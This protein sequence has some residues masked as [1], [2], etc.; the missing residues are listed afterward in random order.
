MTTPEKA[1]E[2]RIRKEL[3]KVRTDP[4]YLPPICLRC[5]HELGKPVI[6][7]VLFGIPLEGKC[8]GVEHEEDLLCSD[9]MED[10]EIEQWKKDGLWEEVEE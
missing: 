1:N 6:I 8:I 2:I 7:G 5:G 3:A 9:C 10:E 4:D